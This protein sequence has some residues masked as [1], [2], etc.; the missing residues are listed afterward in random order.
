MTVTFVANFMNHHQLPFS[1]EMIKLTDGG[2]TFLATSPLYEE[3]ASLGY[4]DMNQRPF[5]IRLYENEAEYNKGMEKIKNDDM[6]IFG[7]CPNEYISMRKATGKPFIIYSERFFKKGLWR[8]FIPITYK[9]VYNRMLRFEAENMRTICSSAYLPYEL[10]LLKSNI[11]TYKWGYFPKHTEYEDIDNLIGSKKKNSIIWVA[12]FIELKHPEVAL[13]IAT[14][15]KK[16]GYDFELNFVGKGE[17]QSF[18]EKEIEKRGLKEHVHILG[19]MSPDMVRAHMEKSEIFLFSS[20]Q[21]EGWGAVMNES[22]NSGCAVVANRLAGAAPYLVEHGKNGFLYNSKDI[23]EAYERVKYLLDNPEKR[24]LMGRNAYETMASKWNYAVAAQRLYAIIDA[25][26]NGKEDPVFE[27]GPCSI[28]KVI[29][30]K[31]RV[32]YDKE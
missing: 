25:M 15:L 12:R 1:E 30:P 14:R 13:E 29:S 4:E 31:G 6:V 11:K 10:K 26:V 32:K 21:R 5:V 24:K 23:D 19:A 3:Q 9:K 16:E 28:A 18:I 7:S 17:M 2:Y 27:D 20:D 8:R 22:M